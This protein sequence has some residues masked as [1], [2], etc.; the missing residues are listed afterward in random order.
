MS[1]FIALSVSF[2]RIAYT[3]PHTTQFAPPGPDVPIPPLELPPC[4]VDLF[5]QNQLILREL[6]LDPARA[7]ALLGRLNSPPNPGSP[8][9]PRGLDAAAKLGQPQQQ[10]S[11]YKTE[12]CR[13][14]EETGACR[15]GAK[16]QVRS[17]RE[18]WSVVEIFGWRFQATSKLHCTRYTRKI[19]ETRLLMIAWFRVS[20]QGL[21]GV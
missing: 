21:A 3:L 7:A 16:C 11:L 18:R 1:S 19:G 13:S 10:N 6:L 8:G 9:G 5:L 12:L 17:D 14:W 20:F 15:Y 2:P 4:H